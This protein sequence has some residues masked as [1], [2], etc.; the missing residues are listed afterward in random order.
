[1]NKKTEALLFHKENGLFGSQQLL[2]H[3]QDKKVTYW[4]MLNKKTT[5]GFNMLFFSLDFFENIFLLIEMEI[6]S[7]R[8]LKILHYEL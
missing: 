6:S 1:M 7:V 8:A 2:W 5:K 4:Q 3:E